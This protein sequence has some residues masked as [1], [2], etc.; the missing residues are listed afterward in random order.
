MKKENLEEEIE[1]T[2]EIIDELKKIDNLTITV[3]DFIGL[4]LEKDI[5]YD[6]IFEYLK[7]LHKG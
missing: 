1:K 6:L 7:T 5:D 3:E 4:C 2:F